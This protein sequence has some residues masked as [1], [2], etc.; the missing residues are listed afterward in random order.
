MALTRL[1]SV[2]CILQASS[3]P[4]PVSALETESGT[5]VCTQM[6]NFMN[7]QYTARLMVGTPPQALQVVPDTGS[8]ELIISSTKCGNECPNKNKYNAGLSTTHA[9]QHKDVET[10]FGQGNVLSEV[11]RDI[12]EIADH[13]DPNVKASAT[14]DV[15]EMKKQQIKNFGRS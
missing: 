5:P 13:I 1:L 12:V 4:V 3:T 7:T 6:T 9:G 11:C 2:A 10:V 14:N 8:R 15:L